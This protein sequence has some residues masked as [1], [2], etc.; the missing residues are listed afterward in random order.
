M[1]NLDEV[2]QT[3]E[4]LLS[5]LRGKLLEVLLISHS[6]YY[7]IING[8]YDGKNDYAHRYFHIVL[9]PQGPL[10]HGKMDYVSPAVGKPRMKQHLGTPE[11]MASHIKWWIEN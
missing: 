4:R 5:P 10:L 1:L 11:D 7:V 3:L 9:I 2:V 6:D 8:Y